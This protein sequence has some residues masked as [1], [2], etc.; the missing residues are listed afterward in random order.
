MEIITCP[1]DTGRINILGSTAASSPCVHHSQVVW[2]VAEMVARV[3]ILPGLN[4][5]IGV[6]GGEGGGFNSPN[7]NFLKFA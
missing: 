2:V 6:C 7:L 5:K 4:R 1:E 3:V